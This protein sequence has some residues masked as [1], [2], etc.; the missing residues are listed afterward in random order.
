MKRS[1]IT[2]FDLPPGRTLAGKYK[3]VSHLGS[4]WEG[5]VYRIT[6][7]RTGIER[8]AKLFYP[9]RNPKNKT[10]KRYAKRLHNLR[11]CQIVIQYHTEEIFR[12]RRA[13]IS[14]LV[15]EF[16]GGEIL[17]DFLAS[18]PG[19]RLTPFEALHL[20]YALAK[21]VECIHRKNEYHGDLHAG[22]VII[23]RFGLEFDLKLLDLFHWDSPKRENRQ[24]DICDLVRILYDSVGGAKHYSKQP[25]AI[26]Y[27]CCGLKRSLIL[28]KFRTVS[29]LR[30]HLETM[31]W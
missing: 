4:G 18:R 16:V 26:K 3:I 20:L 9:Q 25:E 7:I 27:I 30:I 28:E 10:L 24:D 1:V 6:E 14:F 11:D 22:N 15:S 31:E 8:T 5:E 23:S 19:G 29:Q 17:T 21:G 2:A 12:Y 13:T